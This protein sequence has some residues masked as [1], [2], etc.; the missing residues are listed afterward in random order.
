MKQCVAFTLYNRPP[1]V[2]LNTLGAIGKAAL[3]VP[4]TE[5][6]IVDDGSNLD[7]SEIVEA[8]SKLMPMRMI[9][10][11]TSKERPGTYSIN[12]LN[13]PAYASN[14]ALQHVDAETLF[15]MSSDIMPTPWVMRDALTMDLSKVVYMPC[16][17][18]LDS[19]CPYLSPDR[20][21]PYGWFMASATQ[22]FRDVG[23]DE[24]YLKGI[25]FED[26]DFTA[27]LAQKVGRFIID[28][29]WTVWHQSHPQTAYSDDLVGH[30]IN[31]DYTIKKWGGIP[32]DKDNGCPLKLTVG[33]VNNHVLMDVKA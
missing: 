17:V 3:S 1:L 2:L 29:R 18:D 8:M 32:W 25:A 11:D 31:R 19:Q 16:V 15:W 30:N 20:L 21:T 22:N 27:R 26:N 24:E 4:D 23:W 14:F 9:R 33:R 5:V 13:N 10:C 7:Y 6:L 12:G 28:T